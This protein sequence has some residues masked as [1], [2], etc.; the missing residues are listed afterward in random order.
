MRNKTFYII[1]ITICITTLFAMCEEEYAE[2]P[3]YAIRFQNK[4]GQT[5]HVIDYTKSF[6]VYDAFNV[7]P[8]KSSFFRQVADG[9][10][11]STMEIIDHAR[12]YMCIMVINDST[13][14]KYTKEELAESNH[15]DK[16]YLLTFDELKSMNFNII[17]E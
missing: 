6:T 5:I 9:E 17:Y 10:V 1:V 4:S 15:Y 7:L 2:R 13:W 11:D 12:Y 16:R 8:Y 14:N 3:Y